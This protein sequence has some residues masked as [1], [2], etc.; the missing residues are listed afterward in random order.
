M[1]PSNHYFNC[2]YYNEK[3]NIYIEIIIVNNVNIFFI[4]KK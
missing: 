2:S 4:V 1:L 3:K